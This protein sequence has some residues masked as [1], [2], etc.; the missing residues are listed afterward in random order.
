MAY[1][2][3]YQAIS[4][5]PPVSPL[6]PN[7]GSALNSPMFQGYEGGSP[8]PSYL[9]SQLPAFQSAPSAISNTPAAQGLYSQLSNPATGSPIGPATSLAEEA[10]PAATSA[11]SGGLRGIIGGAIKSPEFG[12]GAGANILGQLITGNTRPGTAPHVAGT[13]LATGGAAAGIAGLGV[14]AGGLAIAAPGLATLGMPVTI[15]A[16]AGGAGGSLINHALGSGSGTDFGPFHWHNGGGPQAHAPT[17]GDSPDVQHAIAAA[18]DVHAQG[19]I[20]NSDFAT[21]VK[22]AELNHSLGIDPKQ[23]ASNVI[24]MIQQAAQLQQQRQAQTA[25]NATSAHDQLLQQVAIA[26]LMQPEI[27]QINE[28]SRGLAESIAASRSNLTPQFQPFADM[29]SRSTVEGGHRQAAALTA[30]T[31]ALPQVQALIAS[32]NQQNALQQAANYEAAKQASAS[33]SGPTSLSDLLNPQQAVSV[34]GAG[35]ASGL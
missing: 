17:L 25:S 9:Q 4:S 35:G 30:S 8:L 34:A 31:L 16:L 14:G 21:I 29:L 5:A 15:G 23:T 11:G 10:A 28:G 19:S 20:S 13:A 33:S 2:P 22:Q 26:K 1:F 27:N 32:I 3:P 24:S 12:L 6:A 7:W 18:Q